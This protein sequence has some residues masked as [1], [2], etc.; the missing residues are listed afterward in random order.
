[1]S[2]R[3]SPLSSP[4][5]A[6]LLLALALAS[7]CGLEY[8]QQ[9]GEG[10]TCRDSIECGPGLICV[11][12]SCIEAP[13]ASPRSP[14][15]DQTAPPQVVRDGG[16][17]TFPELPPAQDVDRPR[18]DVV[19]P[20]Q[21]VPPD[22]PDVDPIFLC[23]AG[24][25]ECASNFTVRTCATD[26]QSSTSEECPLGTYCN[27]AR[28]VERP[29][30]VDVDGDGFFSGDDC[31][32]TVDCNDDN[33]NIFPGASELCNGLNDNCQG[34]ADEDLVRGCTSAC[35]RGTQRCSNGRWPECSARQPTPE[36]CGNLIDDDCNGRV[37]DR[38]DECCTPGSCAAGFLCNGCDCVEA[39]ED[40][41]QF[42]NQPCIPGISDNG[43][44][45]CLEFS[46][47]GQTGICVGLCQ[48]DVPNPEA[49]CPEP[50]SVCI[51]GDENQGICLDACDVS[52]QTGCFEG[53]G[54][55]EFGSGACVPAGDVAEGDFCD[56]DQGAFG[57]CA[58]GGACIELGEPE[59]TCERLCNPFAL[60]DNGDDAC[61]PGQ[62]CFPFS[63]DSGICVPALDLNA[64]DSCSR[65]QSGSL[66]SMCRGQSICARGNGQQ[67]ACQD[68][69]RLDGDDC[70]QEQRCRP[71]PTL[72]DVPGVGA[73]R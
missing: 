71:N 63:L 53:Q 47:R 21:D 31:V 27:N 4:L 11:D 64:G 73:C 34:G 36:V 61:D 33:P 12:Q 9:L 20:P 7:G 35:G 39:P 43:P 6:A 10:A 45:F 1:M 19:D 13:L 68:L 22:V 25:R 67:F 5:V 66:L 40:R 8:A 26:R 17:T 18:P 60:V 65:V 2:P 69:C 37:D 28:C 29:N 70:P 44:Y 41:C 59:G 42:Q 52:S 62:A 16:S 57:E 54:C 30:C 23:E 38:C 3:T 49:T 50:G 46:D 14:G 15:D 55:I 72:R 51:F 24:E 58:P 48:L 56:I 32:G